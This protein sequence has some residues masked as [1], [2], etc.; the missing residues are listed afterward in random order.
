MREGS[1]W[2]SLFTRLYHLAP[3]PRYMTLCPPHTRPVAIIETFD[4]CSLRSRRNP[5]WKAM[6]MME[7]RKEVNAIELHHGCPRSAT[8]ESNPIQ[9]NSM[10]P[11]TQNRSLR[12]EK[13]TVL[14]LAIKIS[15]SFHFKITRYAF[16]R[17]LCFT[18]CSAIYKFH[19]EWPGFIGSI[20][21]PSPLHCSSTLVYM[22]ESFFADFRGD[23]DLDVF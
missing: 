12:I 14:F 16:Y 1:E 19:D 15:F 23:E 13:E 11:S 9:Q 10:R 17:L 5:T 4:T 6:M 18:S 21:T 20:V 3:E 7:G 22:N 2:K 8:L